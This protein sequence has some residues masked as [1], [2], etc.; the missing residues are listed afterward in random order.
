MAVDGEEEIMYSDKYEDDEFE[1]RHV[2]LPKKIAQ[3]MPK[4]RLLSEDEWRGLGVCQSLG[5][6]HYMIHRPEPHILL[7]KRRLGTD[8][9][10][11]KL[12]NPPKTSKEAKA[13]HKMKLRHHAEDA[14][15]ENNSR[16][17]NRDCGDEGEEEESDYDEYDDDDDIDM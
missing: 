10:T 5:W 4:D 17:D 13:T 11:G 9:R 7:F 1:Y 3:V 2:T 15:K 14:Y 12:I 6:V 16:Q 8:P